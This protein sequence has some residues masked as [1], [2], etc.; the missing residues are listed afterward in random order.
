MASMN[1]LTKTSKTPSW[2]KAILLLG[3]LLFAFYAST[4]M[5]AAGDTWVALACGRHFDNHG[6]DT[7]EPFSF[8]SHKAGPSD[9]TLSKA[10]WPEWTHGIIRKI[11]PTGWIDQNWLTHLIYYKL[12]T[13]FGK[14]GAYNYDTLVYWKFAIYFITVLVV[15]ALGKVLG[16]PNLLAAAAACLAMV[17][18]RTFFDIRPAGYSNMLVPAFILILALTMCKNYRHIW[19]IVPLIVFWSN[20]HGGYIYA[21]IMLVPFIGINLLLRLP[22]RWSLCLGFVGLWAV[23]YLMSHK[24]VTHEYYLSAQGVLLGHTPEPASLLGN[25]MFGILVFLSLVSVGLTLL[26]KIPAGLFYGYHFAALGIYFLSLIVRFMPGHPDHLNSFFDKIYSY[27]VWSSQLSFIFV[28]IAGGLL[29]SAMAFKKETFVSLPLRGIYHTI[30]ASA[31]AL[32]AMIIFNPFHLT[33]LTHTFEISVSK[34]AESWRQVNEWKPAFDF[35]DK[36][37]T[38]PNPVGEEGWFG[39]MCVLALAAFVIWLA[40]CFLR[41]RPTI[42]NKKGKAAAP[43]PLPESETGFEWPKINLALI[44]IAFLTIY[45]AILSR[46]FIAIAGSAAAPIIALLIYQAWQMISAKIRQLQT[47]RLE[48]WSIPV[49]ELTIIRGFVTLAVVVMAVFWGL[50]YKRIYLDPWPTDPTYNSVFMRM[51]AS[52]LKPIE[53]CDFIRLNKLS[54]RV[55]NYWT[56]GGA[57]ALGQEP[58]PKTGEIPLKLFMDGRA[59]A[60]YNH[61]KFKLWQTIF[62]GGPIAQQASMQ[63]KK[64]TPELYQEIGQWIGQQLDEYHVWVVLMPITQENSVFMKALK[65]TG[66]WKTAYMDDIQHMLVNTQTS[67]GEALI[68]QILKGEALFPN[69]YDKDLTTF[70]VI[71]ENRVTDRYSDLY[72]LAKNAFALN[73]TPTAALLLSSL[74]NSPD[75]QELLAHYLADFVKDQKAYEERA[76]YLQFL[77]TAR[78]CARFLADKKTADSLRDAAYAKQFRE[79]IKT[80]ELQQRW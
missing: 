32:I 47:G 40:A 1:D 30:G 43:S 64:L 48:S 36:T 11:H 66:S 76:G 26:K 69:D 63:G 68:S 65:A 25:K 24:F 72:N 16:V 21:F 28:F 50:K 54:G 67:K 77:N 49:F 39:V 38:T 34:H 22:R 80:I 61:D 12:V 75:A 4:H 53:A 41:P 18:G 15:F 14:D 10:G 9:E 52:H 57:V 8:N 79:E 13:W 31:V 3:M 20:V 71:T 60:A 56:E 62:A 5:V 33:N 55:F 6:V 51:T 35:M 17:V 27:F 2:F 58:D 44:V 29:I 45:M 19:W 78:I 23:L 37:T 74:R 46:R 70:Y 42:T 7:V 73:P 59:Q